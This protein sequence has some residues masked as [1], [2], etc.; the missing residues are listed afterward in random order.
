MEARRLQAERHAPGPRESAVRRR[1]LSWGFGFLSCIE[2]ASGVGF[3]GPSARGFAE[4][5]LAL[6]ARSQTRTRGEMKTRATW[7]FLVLRRGSPRNPRLRCSPPAAL[8]ARGRVR[9]GSSG[10]CLSSPAPPEADTARDEDA[11]VVRFLVLRR[12]SPRNPRLRASPPA[13]VLARG[14]GRHCSSGGCLTSP[15]PPEADAERLALCVTRDRYTVL[16]EASR[17]A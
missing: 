17:A 6:L 8:L 11:G 3:S 1:W 4:P 15:A 5:S 13:A 16:S 12:G 7:G 2:D 9:R 14:R 10:G